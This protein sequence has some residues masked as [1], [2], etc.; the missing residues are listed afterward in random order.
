[1]AEGHAV[2]RWAIA[3]RALVGEEVVSVRA[4]ARWQARAA[5]L[6]GAP[7]ADVRT[8]G[9]HLLLDYGEHVIHCHAMQYGSWQVGEPGMTLRKEPRYIRLHLTTP[10]HEAVY[11]HG[12]V[13]EILTPDEL[14][15]HGALRALGPD[16]L[17]EDF[18]REEVARRMLAAGHR[19]LGDAVLDQRIVA[20]IGNIYKS[21][22]LFLAHLDPR[23]RADS[24]TADE[25]E[26]LW[27]ALIPLMRSGIERFG[28]TVTLPDDLL[29]D[30][31]FNWVYR[32][33]G[34]ECLRCGGTVAMIRQGELE[35]AT[36]F[37]PECQA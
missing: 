27:E 15:E 28:R 4:P 13:M 18:D 8:F 34:R 37:C 2:A 1:M 31:Q 36:Y 10:A 11:Y 29:G 23:R 30:W 21:E 19:A 5:A 7:L 14:A 22:G 32:R 35:R 12:P 16:L 3:L 6:V 9:K 33:R 24:V 25:L 20:G 17:R 26:D